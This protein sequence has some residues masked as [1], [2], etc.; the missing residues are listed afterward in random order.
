MAVAEHCWV[1][2]TRWHTSSAT[3]VR[4]STTAPP[5]STSRP[6][7][8]SATGGPTACPEAPPLASTR[9]VRAA[10]RSRTYTPLVLGPAGSRSVRADAKASTDPSGLSAAW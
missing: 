9:C 7:V 2:S 10:A 6:S 5:T 8:L 1:G 3:P 4:R